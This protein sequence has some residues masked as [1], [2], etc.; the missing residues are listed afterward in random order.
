ME[1]FLKTGLNAGLQLAE[2]VFCEMKGKVNTELTLCLIKTPSYENVL[3]SGG[4]APS[5]PYLGTR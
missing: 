4:T 3:E 2:H 5:I 1:L